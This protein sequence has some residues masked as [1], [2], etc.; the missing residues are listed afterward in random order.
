MSKIIRRQTPS[1]NVGCVSLGAKH[2]IVVQT[3]TDTPTADQELTLRQT[4]ELIEAGAEMV[5]W[6]INDD[7]A[8]QSAISMIKH[9]RQNKV[10]TP[11]V[12][13]FHFNGHLLLSRHESLAEL[14]DKYRINP[15][16]VGRGKLK[17]D[18]FA[19]MIHLAVKYQKAV[20]IGVNGGSLDSEMLLAMMQNN[21]R[22]H[23]PYSDHEVFLSAVVKS[24]LDS[25][26]QALD[27]GLPK[28]K[29]VLS[30]KLS[31][32]EDTVDVYQRMAQ[33]CDIVLHLGLTEAGGGLKG[34]VVSS[35]ALAIL[36]QQ[37]IGDTLR[38]SLTPQPGQSRT[39]EVQVARQILQSMHFRYFEPEIISCPGCG[40]TAS[41]YFQQ[42][43]QQV[44]E[45][46]K[47]RLPDWK[48]KWTGV[49]ELK[50]AVMGCVVNGP[51]ESA[52]AHIGISL[53]GNFEEPLAPVYV[54]GKKYCVLK[55]DNIKQDF[56]NLLEKYVEEH[57][58]KSS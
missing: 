1:V 18:P 26:K 40:R 28:E 10:M 23:K 31:N 17:D 44:Q 25:A 58:D 34:V 29:L 43:A 9:L 8:A 19:T 35:S 30:A 32:V 38:V 15:G 41:A 16:N 2:P 22:H 4:Y 11:I 53:P 5:R 21:E 47:L 33:A 56:F 7:Q 36:L 48:I 52:H 3:M 13:D 6:T 27:L 42:L 14:L 24:V 12:G 46:V 55:G 51:G 54:D 39:Y 37:G 57:H 45:Y 20:R 50:I 49:E